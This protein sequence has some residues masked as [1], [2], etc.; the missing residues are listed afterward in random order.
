M[1]RLVAWDIEK[2]GLDWF[3]RNTDT[4]TFEM[5]DV[6]A[7]DETEM[8]ISIELLMDYS[9]EWDYLIVLTRR[10]QSMAAEIIE[11]CGIPMERV[12]FPL[13]AYS[14]CD[15]SEFAR[16]VFTNNVDRRI[17]WATQKRL[18]E[19]VTCSVD[20]LSY[21]SRS[22]D[23]CIIANMYVDN[24][25][26]AKKDMERFYNL[27]KKFYSFTDDQNVFCDIGA[28]IGTTCIYFKKKLDPEIRILAIEPVESNYTL[29]KINMLLNG[30]D[31]DKE[32]LLQYAVG[33]KDEESEIYISKD[34]SGGNSIVSKS[35]GETQKITIRSFDHVLEEYQIN[36]A[37]IKYMWVDV[38]GY[39]IQ[40]VKGALNTL[41]RY[42]I[43]IVMEFIPEVVKSNEGVENYINILKQ[44]YS[45]LVIMQEQGDIVHRME[46]LLLYADH[47]VGFDLFLLK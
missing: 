39:E 12:I 43:P 5:I 18:H 37:Q 31:H 47:E 32:I 24:E 22:S 25:N 41:R 6:I 3:D 26:W 7:T 17:A 23:N 34:N 13:D 15:H 11:K 36:P 42:D 40:F 21:I 45:G 9:D 19:Y 27:S 16:Q 28:N 44:V 2:I 38:E 46:D 20:G 33:E 4:S 14:L 30:L 10:F 29:L 8:G 35:S 1:Y